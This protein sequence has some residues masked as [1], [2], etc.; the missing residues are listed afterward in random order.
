MQEQNLWKCHLTVEGIL[1]RRIISPHIILSFILVVAFTLGAIGLDHGLPYFPHIDEYTKVYGAMKIAALH[2]KSPGWF[3][4]PG[5]TLIYPLAFVYKVWASVSFG[6][7]IWQKN[8]DLVVPLKERP[9]ATGRLV[10]TD[11]VVYYQIARRFNL[12]YFVVGIAVTYLVG[13][14]TWDRRVAL[15]AAWFMAITP[16]L[17]KYA[18]I[19]RTDHA[20]LLFF[21]LGFL[22][23]FRLLSSREWYDYVIAGVAIGTA[24][25]SRYFNLSLGAT[26]ILVHFL[27]GAHR[28]RGHWKRLIVGL[29][30]IGFGFLITSPAWIFHLERVYKDLV[31]HEM[32]PPLKPSLTLPGK[33]WWYLSF[34]LP[35]VLTWPILLLAIAGVLLVWR[36][37]N[38]RATLLLFGFIMF[39]LTIAVPRLYEEHWLIPLIPIGLLFAAKAL[40]TGIDALIARQGAVR[41]AKP[42][43]ILLLI[44]ASIVPLKESI[45]HVYLMT[46]P[47]TRILAMEWIETNLPPGS[48]IVREMH[49]API[50]GD[51]F[52]VTF[53]WKLFR[54]GP[55]D[56]TLAQQYDYFITSS[57]IYERVFG[58]TDLAPEIPEFYT[59][60]FEHELVV[61]FKPD[62]WKTPGPTIRIYRMLES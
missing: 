23:C 13:M 50:P 47:D 19:A 46:Q 3:G 61:E 2:Y 54:L 27:T 7:P 8:P 36:E 44:A 39:V 45:E 17:L 40:W 29:I 42:V 5:S 31:F 6:T 62:P 24:G 9:T 33:L 57:V 11:A 56:E 16:T 15:L 58:N 43:L 53:T 12:L 38:K 25:S 35:D 30:A 41:W 21:M 48:R 32:R 28:E 55:F 1:K 52:S 49:T 22:A 60:L 4:H 59:R 37:R 10:E 51:D 26:L 14:R 18:H 20:G 34:A